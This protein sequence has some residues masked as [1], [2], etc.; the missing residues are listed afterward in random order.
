MGNRRLSKSSVWGG[1][2]WSGWSYFFSTACR[3]SKPA[4]FLPIKR[5]DSSARAICSPRTKYGALSCTS[6]K[7]I[8]IGFGQTLWFNRGTNPHRS[9]DILQVT[10]KKHLRNSFVELTLS[11]EENSVLQ[12]HSVQT[13]VPKTNR[14]FSTYKHLTYHCENPKYLTERLRW[15]G[16]IEKILCTRKNELC[17]D[18]IYLP[19]RRRPTSPSPSKWIEIKGAI[20][21]R[22]GDSTKK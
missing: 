2:F 17:A 9:R 6:T 18:Q 12:Q 21:F 1:K 11:R 5:Q 22:F 16:L 13:R 14:I 19:N 15:K 4:G 10:R 7:N 3:H 8:T 20:I